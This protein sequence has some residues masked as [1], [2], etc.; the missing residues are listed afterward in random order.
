MFEEAIKD[1]GII[2]AMNPNYPEVYYYMGMCKSELLDIDAAINDFF[3]AFELGS[4]NNSI[5]NG[6][7][8]AYLKSNRCEKALVYANMALEK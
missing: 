2:L 5:L 4:R 1:F 6:I 8:F 3:K 7:S